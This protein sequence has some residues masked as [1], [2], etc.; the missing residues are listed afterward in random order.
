VEGCDV[1]LGSAGRLD[2]Q[3][4]FDRLLRCLEE[5][6]RAMPPG[7]RWGLVILGEGPERER[8]Q[9]LA[10]HSPP[11]LDVV[12]PGFQVDAASAIGAFDLLL[13]P[14]RSEGFGL[15]AAEGMAHGIPVLAEGV[16]ALPEILAGYPLGK[17]AAFEPGRAPVELVLELLE[18]G[19]ERRPYVPFT[20][21]RMVESYLQIYEE[22]LGAVT[23]P[24]V[25]ASNQA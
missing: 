6:G 15:T 14:S 18:K 11:Q 9:E 10:L 12:L 5:I 25:K 8:L 22:L 23:P 16:G 21:E 19:R 13:V 3:K 1:V 17:L 20:V 24:V 7:E 4:G 2:F